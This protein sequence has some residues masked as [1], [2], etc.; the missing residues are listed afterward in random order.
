MQG[1]IDGWS[2]KAPTPMDWLIAQSKAVPRDSPA[3]N[4]FFDIF[5]CNV[6][7]S[8]RYVW[9]T[10]N[11]GSSGSKYS[12]YALMDMGNGLVPA[13]NTAPYE[14]HGNWLM[15]TRS[16][17]QGEQYYLVSVRDGRPIQAGFRAHD[18][19]RW[20]KRFFSDL[21]GAFS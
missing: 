13:K 11:Q 21:S 9:T 8:Y 16:L 10:T 3:S 17:T 12:P 1:L 20:W 5:L 4:G 2:G 19:V 14:D 15:L 6:V 18:F 7:N